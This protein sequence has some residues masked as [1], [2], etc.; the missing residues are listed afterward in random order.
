MSASVSTSRSRPRF[1][2]TLPSPREHPLHGQIAKLLTI[3]IAPAGRLS[4]HSVVWWSID[5]A[6]YAGVPGTRVARGIVAG[7]PDIYILWLGRSHAIE[8]KTAS[9]IFSDAQRAICAAILG[10]GGRV[11]AVQS[12][13]DALA[14][15]DE[16]QIPRKHRTH[17]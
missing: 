2:L 1:K 13:D 10:A 11:T 15:L 17:L 4:E 16:W 12:A 14:A 9:G 7:V 3:E 5:I 6:D 8:I